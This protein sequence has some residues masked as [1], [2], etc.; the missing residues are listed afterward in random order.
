MT[1][2]EDSDENENGSSVIGEC[3]KFERLIVMDDVSR[4]VDKSDILIAF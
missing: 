4:L 2:N 1:K 3:N